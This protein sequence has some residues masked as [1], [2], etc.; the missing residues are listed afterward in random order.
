MLRRSLLG[1]LGLPILGGCSAFNYQ[2]PDAP[3]PLPEPPSLAPPPKIALVLGAG[4]PRGYAHLGVLR[5]LEEK[6]VRPDL[7]VGS[8]VGALIGT[9]WA[10]GL[11]AVALD[12]LSGQGGPLTLFD[13][14]PFAD[15]GWIHGQRL[16]DYV[17]A[18]VGGRP[19]EALPRRV[20]VVAT[21]RDDKAARFITQ[22]HA[23]VAVRASSAVPGIVSPV[24]IDGVEYE[25][26]DESLPLAV[27][28]AR[29]AG[30]QFVIAVNVYPRETPASASSKQRARD[31]R[32]R[33]LMAP[34]LP[35]ADFVL[36][37]DAGYETGP[38]QRYFD[39]ARQAGERE[40]RARWPQLE[41]VLRAKLYR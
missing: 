18:G 37:A 8:S 3:R 2:G 28:A 4:G 29:Q 31:E 26:G 10:S 23:G 32:R 21:R 40:M 19:L 5:V 24:G 27:Q 15:R 9:F 35:F 30:A 13:P 38:L 7:I 39:A 16:Q 33:R 12:E 22:G 41:E 14:S 25:D 20:I 36:Q 1:L 34:E 6:G 11:D 17:Q